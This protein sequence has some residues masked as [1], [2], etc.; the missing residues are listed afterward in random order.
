[1]AARINDE[2]RTNGY[3]IP[4]ISFARGRDRSDDIIEDAEG[5]ERVRNS[6]FTLIEK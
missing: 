1:M 6:P 4:E 3:F 5:H 2:F